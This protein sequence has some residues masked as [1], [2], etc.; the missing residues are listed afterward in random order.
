MHLPL[1]HASHHVRANPA[2]MLHPGGMTKPLK[3]PLMCNFQKRIIDYSLLALDMY[4]H[5]SQPYQA[6]E[7]IGDLSQ[8]NLTG[9][10]MT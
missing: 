2:T 8:F 9:I 7:V 5:V 4:I 6:V 3:F 10:Y 1:N